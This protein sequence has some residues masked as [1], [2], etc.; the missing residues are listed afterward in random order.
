MHAR[1][2]LIRVSA[3]IPENVLLTST[4]SLNKMGARVF[5]T[6]ICSIAAVYLHFSTDNSTVVSRAQLYLAAQALSELG[7]LVDSSV[8][9]FLAE[10][11]EFFVIIRMHFAFV[12]WFR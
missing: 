4:I 9:R 10:M 8:L 6:I 11:A 5:W 1:E 7:L 3:T 2:R 12:K